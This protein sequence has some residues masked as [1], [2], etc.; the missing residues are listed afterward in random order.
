MSMEV[1]TKIE[2]CVCVCTRTRTSIDFKYWEPLLAG[3]PVLPQETKWR[4]LGVLEQCCES[5]HH[6]G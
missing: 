5:Q 3:I 1:P 4:S 6:P 2:R